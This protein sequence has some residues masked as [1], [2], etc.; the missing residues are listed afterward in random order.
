MTGPGGAEHL[1]EQ[2]DCSLAIA[3]RIPAS[4][5]LR[6]SLDRLQQW[7][8]DR[9]DATYADLRA[10]ERFRP[11]CDFFLNDLYGGRDVHERDRQLQRVVPVMRRFLPDHLLFAVGEAMHLQAMSLQLDLELSGFLA[12]VEVLDQRKYASGFR[13]HAAW[14]A[15][16]EQIRLIRELGELLERTVQRS[17]VRQLVA[18]MQGPAEVTGV[19]LLHS[20][21]RRGLDAFARMGRAGHFLETI[22][23]RECQ[24]LAAMRKGSE[25]PFEPWIGDGPALSQS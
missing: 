17:M 25:Q 9:L 7:Q 18:I 14:E 13:Q 8:R 10:Q 12:D 19:G 11:A 4:G 21:L 23:V 15:R 3:A 2:I 24:V 6:D 5:P 22:E 16:H 1:A 20:F